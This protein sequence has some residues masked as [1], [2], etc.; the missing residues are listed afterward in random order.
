MAKNDRTQ[1]E[2]TAH[3]NYGAAGTDLAGGYAA[4][5]NQIPP[6]QSNHPE[7]RSHDEEA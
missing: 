5:D 4:S 1:Y 3:I 6:K 7:R 2:K